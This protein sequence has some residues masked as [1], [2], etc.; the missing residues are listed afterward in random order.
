LMT[1][2][3]GWVARCEAGVAGAASAGGAR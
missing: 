2:A 1:N 3:V